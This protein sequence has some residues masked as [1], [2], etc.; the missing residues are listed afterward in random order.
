MRASIDRR[1]GE[2]VALLEEHYARTT[3]LILDAD[4]TVLE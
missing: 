3:G 4:P 1:A 2:A